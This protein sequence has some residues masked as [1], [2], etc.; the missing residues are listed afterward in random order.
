MR[1]HSAASR[2]V[3]Y[4]SWSNQLHS[5]MYLATPIDLMK[6]CGILRRQETTL[7]S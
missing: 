7:V 2:P 6:C 3:K 1:H 4:A 5:L